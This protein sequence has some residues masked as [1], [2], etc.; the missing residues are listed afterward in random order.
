MKL[1]QFKFDLPQEQI[2]QYPA[3]HRD[4]CRMMVNQ[5]WL[6]ITQLLMPNL[7]IQPQLNK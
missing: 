1:S 4:E 5:L 2:A 7:M 6:Q 3:P